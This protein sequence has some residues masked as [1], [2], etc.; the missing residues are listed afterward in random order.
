M[1]RPVQTSAASLLDLFYPPTLRP[2]LPTRRVTLVDV[3]TTDEAL[4]R[5][6]MAALER[7]RLERRARVGELTPQQRA[8]RRRQTVRAAKQRYRA[9]LRASQL[10]NLKG[11]PQ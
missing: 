9:R 7:A 4:Q 5:Q 8:D 1:S 6:R 10:H 3:E 11:G 2:A